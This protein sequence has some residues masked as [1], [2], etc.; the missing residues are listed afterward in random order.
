[1]C[2]L[3]CLTLFNC[4]DCSPPGS[5]VYGGSPSKKTGVCFHAPFRGSSQPKNP[6]QVHTLPI[7]SVSS[8][9][10]SYP[11]LCNHKDCSTPGFSV[12]QQIPEPTSYTYTCIADS[13]SHMLTLTPLYMTLSD[14]SWMTVSLV[15]GTLEQAAWSFSHEKQPNI[16]T[17]HAWN[18]EVVLWELKSW[19]TFETTKHLHIYK[20]FHE[21]L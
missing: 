8:V 6:T 13:L 2:Y 20:V 4:L 3:S 15:L 21:K 18:S 14:S 10:Q 17:F 7:S 9:A 16:K 5:S 19:K 12:H 11:T 1:M